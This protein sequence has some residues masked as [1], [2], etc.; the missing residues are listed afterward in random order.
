MLF[1][2]LFGI[3]ILQYSPLLAGATSR[4][5]VGGDTRYHCGGG[6]RI[7]GAFQRRDA[8]ALLSGMSWCWWS[9]HQL[10]NYHIIVHFHPHLAIAKVRIQS[11]MSHPSNSRMVS[12]IIMHVHPCTAICRHTLGRINVNY[13]PSINCEYYQT[14][15]INIFC[16]IFFSHQ[17]VSSSS[18]L[19]LKFSFS[20]RAEPDLDV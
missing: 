14:I 17:I 12:I 3:H 1:A 8:C 15:T 6:V 16:S 7:G 5:H 9:R 18:F 11:I 10:R 4:V 2:P 20:R 19:R 13:Q